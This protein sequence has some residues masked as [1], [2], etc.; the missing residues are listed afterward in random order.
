M[1]SLDRLDEI[2][3]KAIRE[4]KAPEGIKVKFH[5]PRAPGDGYFYAEG[6]INDMKFSY[7][8]GAEDIEIILKDKDDIIYIEAD[9]GE[10]YTVFVNDR[11]YNRACECDPEKWKPLDEDAETTQAIE[12]GIEKLKDVR[13]YL[14]EKVP[15]FLCLIDGYFSRSLLPL[16][17][18]PAIRSNEEIFEKFSAKLKK[19]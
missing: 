2:V 5:K 14:K 11:E 10:V 7:Q 19:A 12:F 18:Q 16:E 4:I 15:E 6:R 3:K 9:E 17:D 8:H 1:T 13:E